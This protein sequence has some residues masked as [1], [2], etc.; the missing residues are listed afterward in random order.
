M[1]R[2]QDIQD[3]IDHAASSSG[4]HG[5]STTAVANGIPKAA[6]N[7]KIADGWISDD[8]AKKNASGTIVVTELPPEVVLT[9]NGTI[10]L[11][12]LPSIISGKTFRSTGNTSVTGY[13][14]AD[15]TDLI[16]LINTKVAGALNSVDNTSTNYTGMGPGINNCDSN[17][18]FLQCS[19]RDANLSIPATG[20]VRLSKSVNCNCNCN[21][22]S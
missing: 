7:G 10:P 19:L 20:L 16:T 9:V 15:G 21:C 6:A 11:A 5:F 13:Q 12:L 18:S 4:I 2:P 14:L 22:C 3:L 17:C 1:P 8:F